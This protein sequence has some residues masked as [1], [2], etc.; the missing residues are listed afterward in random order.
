MHIGRFTSLSGAVA[1]AAFALVGAAQAGEAYSVEIVGASNGLKEALESASI[2]AGRKREIATTA[3]LRRLAKDDLEN[4]RTTLRAAGYY[5]GAASVD[6]DADSDP[7]KPKVVFHVDPGKKFRIEAYEINYADAGEA[8]RPTSLEAVKIKPNGAADGASL[9]D[10]QTAFLNALWDRGYPAARIVSR[11][12][13]ADMEAGTARA[14]FVLDSGPHATFGEI[15]VSGAKDASPSYLRKLKTWKPG[16]TF[17]HSKLVVYRDKLAATGLFSS[18]DLAPGAPNANGRAPI[19]LT[20]VERKRRT[21]GVGA[22]YSTTE[23]PGGRLFF[24]YRNFFH[25]GELAHVEFAGTKVQQSLGLAINK[26]LPALPGEA[27]S[28]LQLINETPDAY[29]ARTL[30]V[31]GGLSHNWL[32]QRLNTTGALALET[33]K[34]RSDVSDVRTYFISAPLTVTWNSENNL[35]NPTKGVRVALAVTPYTGTDNFTVMEL[36]ARS[37][38]TFGPDRRFTLAFR[39]RLGSIVGSPLSSLP[40]NKRFYAGGGASVRG[41]GYQDVGPFDADNNPTGG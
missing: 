21:I 12:A 28:S 7:E 14:V 35:L 41:Y 30:R 19:L 18:I 40:S 38:A 13:V 34:V 23:G 25:H 32:K 6:V 1:A 29:R 33:S 27:F 2:I 8:D 26:P 9:Q 4:F 20:V 39:G 5:A 15:K 37:R 24:D 11:H 10:L 16:E 3:A 22:S 31:S 17:D 36:N